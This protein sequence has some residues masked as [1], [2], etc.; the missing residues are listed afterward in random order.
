MTR[1][2]S[3]PPSDP[4]PERAS[5]LV[6]TVREWIM[7]LENAPTLSALRSTHTDTARHVWEAIAML[8]QGHRR[9]ADKHLEDAVRREERSERGSILR[10]GD[11]KG[12]VSKDI[13]R[14]GDPVRLRLQREAGV[15]YDFYLKRYDDPDLILRVAYACKALY[16]EAAAGSV[17][18][19]VEV[20]DYTLDHRVTAPVPS[21]LISIAFGPSLE[22]TLPDATVDGKVIAGALLRNTHLLL[23][24]LTRDGDAIARAVG[25]V[26]E[27][28]VPAATMDRLLSRS[29]P[30][31][32]AVK[33]RDALRWLSPLFPLRGR[34][35][36]RYSADAALAAERLTGA[37]LPYVDPKA[38]N[39]VGERN[40]DLEKAF[41]SRKHPADLFA[42][43]LFDPAIA[44]PL[45]DRVAMLAAAVAPYRTD[46]RG[47]LDGAYCFLVRQSGIA[48]RGLRAA[49]V[50]Q[51]SGV[52]H[53]ALGHARL[54]RELCALPEVRSRWTA[55]PVLA[56]L[57]EEA[58]RRR[59][60][61]QVD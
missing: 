54:L 21:R 43:V 49:T 15:P 42:H 31:R 41:L 19:P 60:R 16:W 12:T 45:V 26:P 7:P 59:V 30:E 52:L 14:L 25:I 27:Y 10:Y 34:V 38:A 57:P 32:Y 39:F 55:A 3:C 22:E 61:I 50:G 46:E 20:C 4:F 24:Y 58:F 2:L 18:P 28:L 5:P 11:Q 37:F 29:T 56:D 33:V 17:V 51:V 53:R 8:A 36:L 47:A 1:A 9:T 13:R 23:H 44:L 40:I 48:T 6:D 35:R